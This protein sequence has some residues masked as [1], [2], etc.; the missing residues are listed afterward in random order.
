ML[1]FTFEQHRLNHTLVTVKDLGLGLAVLSAAPARAMTAHPAEQWHGSGK[2]RP[3]C[4]QSAPRVTLAFLTCP[5]S[6]GKPGPTRQD[7]VVGVAANTIAAPAAVVALTG[8]Y[9][10]RRGGRAHCRRRLSLDKL[11]I[12]HAQVGRRLHS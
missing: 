11:Q 4:F 2:A 6:S 5:R 3:D 10:V 7:A 9:T 12:A 1:L 8:I